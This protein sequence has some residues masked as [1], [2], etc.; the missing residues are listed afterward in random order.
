MRIVDKSWYIKPPKIRKR[1]A[2]GGVIIRRIEDRFY[3]ALIHERNYPK[4]FA[5]PKGGV[6]K[7]ESLLMAALREIHEEAGI[8]DLAMKQ[9]LGK[10]E[11]L[12]F[13]KRSWNI[14]HYF[15]FFTNQISGIPTD[16]SKSYKLEWFQIDKAPQLFWPDQEEILE[17]AK[18]ILLK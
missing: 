1:I 15:L 10:R 16:T 4:E 17:E 2:S 13:S 11:R 5:L 8:T 12:S 14:I 18:K 3:V 6:E 7:G 9:Y